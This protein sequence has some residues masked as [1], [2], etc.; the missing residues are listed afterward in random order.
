MTLL[1]RRQVALSNAKFY[2]VS[3]HFLNLSPTVQGSLGLVGSGA[4]TGATFGILGAEAGSPGIVR[5]QTGTTATG[6]YRLST[7]LGLNLSS[8]I[9]NLNMRVRIP[10]LS[11]GAQ[12]FTAELGFGEA[13]TTTLSAN[14]VFFLHS[15]SSANWSLITRNGGVQTVVD[16]SPIT[17]NTWY[18]LNLRV[19]D[20]IAIATI[21]GTS[22]TSSTN[23]PTA[24]Q[25]LTLHVLK[26]AGAANRFVDIDYMRLRIET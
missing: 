13:A 25:C 4:G 5:P 3:D 11:T 17:A 9:W 7:P 22:Y 26:A 18:D 10:T 14:G 16:C 1:K 20:G 15:S 2:E 6:Y 24:N 19:G 12:N 21:D 23:L 8:G